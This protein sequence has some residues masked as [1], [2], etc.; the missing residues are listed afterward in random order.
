[1][2]L[3]DNDLGDLEGVPEANLLW[4]EYK[5]RHDLIWKHLIRSTTA[6]VAL[7]TVQYLAD[8]PRD[9]LLV[10]VAFFLA[11]GYTIFTYWVLQS[12]L[13]LYEQV[14]KLH[15]KRQRAMFGLHQDEETN[16]ISGF[17]KRVRFYIIVLF[18]LSVGATGI[19]YFVR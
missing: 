6:V 14:K 10:G 2:Q 12:E 13:I 4:D 16:E 7:L 18:L 1:M 9:P 11:I 5:Y 19:Y 3:D 15:R 8:L 17:S